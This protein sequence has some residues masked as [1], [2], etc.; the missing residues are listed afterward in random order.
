MAYLINR[1]APS[2]IECL[3]SLIKFL[4]KNYKN[5]SFR[6]DDCMFSRDEDNIHNYCS[7]I[8]KTVLGYK[9]PYKE[10]PL[11]DAG[12]YI[13][14]GKLEDTTKKKEVSNTINAL[15]G[16]GFLIRKDHDI[17]I[18]ELGEQAYLQIKQHA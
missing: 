6:L 8:E 17:Y 11:S 13:T 4:Y 3:H 7:L 2:R 9:C 10:S 1:N 14:N 12:C 18:S 16:M 15:H 5:T